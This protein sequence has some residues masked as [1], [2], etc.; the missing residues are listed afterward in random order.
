MNI[1]SRATPEGLESHGL[2]TTGLRHQHHWK[3]PSW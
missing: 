3:Y 1:A 2:S